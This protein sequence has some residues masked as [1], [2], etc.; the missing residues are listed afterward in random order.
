M[1][2]NSNSKSDFVSN[3]F[4]TSTDAKIAYFTNFNPENKSEAFA[5]M[6]LLVFNYGLV[7]SNQHW[8]KQ[9]PFFSSKSYPILLHDYRGHYASSLPP[10]GYGSL[11]FKNFAYDIMEL[12]HHLGFSQTIMFGHSM[13]VNVT[14]E[15]A[16]LFPELVLGMVLISGSVLSPESVMFDSNIMEVA[17]PFV[18]KLSQKYPELFRTVWKTNP[19][20][21][22]TQKIIRFGGFNIGR[23]PLSFI[24]IYLEKIS[25]LGPD[26]FFHLFNRMRE[27][28][29]LAYLD[30]I[31]PPALIISGEKDKVIPNHFQ[32]IMKREL[33]RS[34]FYLVKEGS[35]VP[36]V[37]FPQKVNERINLF[38]T[39][40]LYQKQ[41]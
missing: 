28:D 35:H 3:F 41:Q 31:A 39:P 22:L 11:T 23:V 29:I 32:N 30:Q 25:E 33:P 36:Q 38:I 8:S 7:C 12:V 27:H 13:G 9:I 26:L 21:T 14:L 19:K 4:A 17:Y 2:N 24:K 6:P 40:L 10:E 1:N 34:E 20:L 18:E 37:D 5:G 15:F 16:K